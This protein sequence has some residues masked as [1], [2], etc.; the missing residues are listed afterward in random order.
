MLTGPIDATARLL[1]RSGMTMADIDTVEINEAFASVVLAWA[2]ETG[3]DPETINGW[4]GAIALGHPLGASGARLTATLLSRLEDG[5]GRYGLQT[6]CEGG[7]MANAM[8]VE[9]L[10]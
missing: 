8:L 1:E 9:R 4:G 5:N 6:M 3:A 10:G 2:A 7:G